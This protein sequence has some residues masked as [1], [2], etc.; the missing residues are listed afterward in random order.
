[1]T[2]LVRIPVL[3][4]LA[5]SALLASAGVAAAQL[6]DHETCY[7]LSDPLSLKGIV[8]LSSD[9]G[10][11]PG[12]RI[13]K[14]AVLCMPSAA[15]VAS[16]SVTPLPFSASPAVGPRVCYK[17]KCP[18]AP[19]SGLVATD[20]FGMRT[21][22]SVKKAALLCVPATVGDTY[23]GDGIVD[24]DE[25]CEPTDLNLATCATAGFSGGV[26]ACGPGC[27]FDTSGCT[28]T[29]C[30]GGLP[31]TG[32]TVSHVS[33]DDGDIQ[34]G[35]P[36]SYTDNFDGTITD[37]NTGLMW[38]KKDRAGGLHDVDARF[39]WNAGPGGIWEWIDAIN[40]EDGHG[41][42]WWTDWRIPN[43]RELQ[44]IQ[45]YTRSYPEPQVAPIFDTGCTAGCSLLDCSCTAAF[46]TWS[47]TPS[48]D[49]FEAGGAWWLRFDL[50][51]TA[52][53]SKSTLGAVRAVRGGL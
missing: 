39:H 52:Y 37:N 51:M 46:E 26:L 20:R 5:A 28:G 44:T 42:G 48:A 50:G 40:A 53:G 49:L 7:K 21:L 4:V 14:S 2:D 12:C 45:I 8:D 15:T 18:T 27:R 1:M 16:A 32:W 41:L 33:G 13:G 30:T 9:F 17:V 43:M 23:C 38:E 25:Q 36:L 3:L 29:P 47:S 11:E 6:E 35:K 19:A 10:L 34:A 24:P 22:T 31:A